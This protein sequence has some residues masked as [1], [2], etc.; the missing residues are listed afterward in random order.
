[1]HDIVKALKNDPQVAPHRISVNVYDQKA[2]LSGRVPSR[3]VKRRAEDV[4][5]SVRGLV[6]VTNTLTVKSMNPR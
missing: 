6:G 5:S 2:Y 3:A 1:M 4:A